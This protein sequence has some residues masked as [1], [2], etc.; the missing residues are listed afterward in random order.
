MGGLSDQQLLDLSTII[1]LDVLNTNYDTV[2]HY[3]NECVDNL[4]Q[5]IIDQLNYTNNNRLFCCREPYDD[6]Q[7][8]IKCESNHPL[9]WTWIH[10]KC[11]GLTSKQYKKLSLKADSFYCPQ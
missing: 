2:G 11:S 7:N 4:R 1:Y 8:Y 9:C 3:I 10:R 5:E 6:T